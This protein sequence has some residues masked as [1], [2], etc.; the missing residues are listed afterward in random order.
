MDQH[1]KSILSIFEDISSIPR[2]SKH[3]EQI[4]KWL[5][6]WAVSHG[7][8]FKYDS[9]NNVLITVPASPGYEKSPTVVIQGHM[10]MVCEKVGSYVHDFERD[11]IKL[12]YDGKWLRADGTTLGADNGIGLAMALKLAKDP[13]VNHPPLE[14]LFTVDEE[15]SMQG[16]NA[17]TPDFIS[18]KILI[19][20][21]SEEEGVFIVGCAGGIT[22]HITMNVTRV[23]I[24]A[25]YGICKLIAEGMCGG[26]SGVNIHEKRAN[27]IKVIATAIDKLMA[28]DI[29]LVS[30]DGGSAHNAIP[31]YSQAIVAYS[32]NNFA[33]MKS[34][35]TQLESELRAEF[36]EKEPEL[37]IK[38][39][40]MDSTE[41]LQSISPEISKKLVNLL[42][43]L[44]HG[45]SG[46]A[47]DMP[48]LVETSSNLASVHTGNVNVTIITSQR[49]SDK[50]KLV[51]LTNRINEIARSTG[52]IVH[53]NE[54]YPSWKPNMRSPLLQKCREVYTSL[55][56][57]KPRV[58][59]IHAGLEC[60]IM[61]S[62]FKELDMISFGPTIKNPHSP[63]ECLYIP[64]VSKVWNF[65]VSLLGAIK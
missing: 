8:S 2:C 51:H 54:G 16:A 20:L 30:I 58:K 22:S 63:D 10:D 15:T 5:K 61:G 55:Y 3:E 14:L 7:L 39:E 46:M 4:A 24:P 42:L 23:L 31:R 50:E 41:K 56:H 48:G 32:V 43:A 19:N 44:P 49:S 36:G 26:H 12:I 33:E 47:A 25:S 62:I 1:T 21:D 57:E 27:S 45:V 64:S 17:L 53:N 34:T 29:L 65:L 59:S 13:D 11:P 18:G 38:I 28:Y 40:K 37:S 6:E 52:A 9:M 35:I 60:A